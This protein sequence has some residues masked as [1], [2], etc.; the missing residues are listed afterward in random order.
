MKTYIICC[1]FV[2]KTAPAVSSRAS[3]TSSSSS[4]SKKS[5][6]EANV[7]STSTEAPTTTKTS[8]KS[9]NK[10][11]QKAERERE[12]E[13]NNEKLA[14]EEEEEQKKKEVESRVPHLGSAASVAATVA[15]VV[16]H[17]V[18]SVTMAQ[19]QGAATIMSSRANNH[20]NNKKDY[21]SGSGIGE[22]DDFGV[23]STFKMS[24]REKEKN[25]RNTSDRDR[26]SKVSSL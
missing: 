17:A 21:S 10:R 20:R 6:N 13:N 8:S 25:Q 22:L 9:K 23:P 16:Q 3:S 7:A 26:N 1:F 11:K 2:G 18:A 19:G 12:K 14:K 5:K 24:P 15:A 4:S